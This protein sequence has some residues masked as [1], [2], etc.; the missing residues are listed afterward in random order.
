[1]TNTRLLVGSIVLLL[2]LG[3]FL[4][5]CGAKETEPGAADL[6]GKALTEER[7]TSCHGLQTITSANKSRDGWQS[8]VERMIGKGAQLTDAEKAAVIDYLAEAYPE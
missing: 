1:M 2:V 8:T 6:D 7:C 3:L 4:T 5:A